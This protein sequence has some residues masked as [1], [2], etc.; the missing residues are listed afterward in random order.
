MRKDVFKIDNNDNVDIKE[1][2]WRILR[3]MGEFVE[4][5]ESM[6]H[7]K[8]AVSIFGSAR[9]PEDHKSYKLAYETA[10][11]LSENAYTIITGGGPG[12]MEAGNRGAYEAGGDSIG[13]CIELPFEQKTN[14]YVKE[15]IKFRYFFARKVMFVKY[16]KAFVVFPGG[17]G[18]MDEMF[19][20]ITLMQ[21]GILTKFPII[22]MDIDYYHGLMEWVKN[23]ML[24]EKYINA[25]DL[26]LFRYAKNAEEALN[27]IQNFY[28]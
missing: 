12:I 11:L 9:T 3:I 28:N 23:T 5:F 18:T 17:F 27:I 14:P 16:A 21:T 19:E 24:K 15:E 7:Y 26:D 20:A 2:S 13:L 6:A 10:K 1:E 4:G 8:N 22:I 25:S